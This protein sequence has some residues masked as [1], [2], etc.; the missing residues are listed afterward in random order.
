MLL[1]TECLLVHE[2]RPDY[3]SVLNTYSI[4]LIPKNASSWI[5]NVVVG[6]VQ[7]IDHFNQN[8]VCILRDPIDRWTVGVAEFL[9]SSI[10]KSWTVEQVI[11][12]FLEDNEC[13]DIHTLPQIEFVQKLDLHNTTWFYL[14]E[15]FTQQFY[16]WTDYNRITLNRRIQHNTNS[17]LKNPQKLK[18]VKFYQDYLEKNPIAKQK[19]LNFYKQ[20]Y[21]LISGVKFYG[22]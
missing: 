15:N 18:L 16:K 2:Y 1:P 12:R 13:L 3:R 10:G 4:V 9:M 8:T 14:N 7:G 11:E 17:S 21:D 22:N 5:K 19:I 6:T 20:D